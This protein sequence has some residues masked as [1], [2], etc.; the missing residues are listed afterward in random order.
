MKVARS[1]CS[2]SFFFFLF[3]FLFLGDP[4]GGQLVSRSQR[5]TGATPR[6]PLWGTGATSTSSA[7][8]SMAPAFAR[9]SA[10]YSRVRFAALLDRFC[11]IQIKKIKTNT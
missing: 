1:S 2:S 5:G 11:E 10:L 3:T 7:S 4:G 6:R 9:S 8:P